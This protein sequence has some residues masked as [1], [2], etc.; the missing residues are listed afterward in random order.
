MRRAASHIPSK[1]ISGS[2]DGLSAR[3]LLSS[4]RRHLRIGGGLHAVAVR[5]GRL[6]RPRAAHLVPSGSGSDHSRAAATHGGCPRAAGSGARSPAMRSEV[7]MLQSRSVIEPVVRSLG[8]WRMPEFQPREYPGGWRWQNLEER[9]R[10][11]WGSSAARMR[12]RKAA[13]AAAPPASNRPMTASTPSQAVIDEA[14]EKYAR[15]SARRDGWAA[16]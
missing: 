5:R 8:L 13:H 3:A 6:C 9:L 4:I 15:L 14:V 1:P 2:E 16:R 7:D 12:A 10:D 11:I